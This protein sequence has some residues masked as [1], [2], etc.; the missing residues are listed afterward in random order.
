LAKYIDLVQVLATND[1]GRY[2]FAKS[3]LDRDAIEYSVK[4]EAIRMAHG[5]TDS[6]WTDSVMEP[7][8]FWVRSE[9]AERALL[10]L[11]DLDT[12]PL[13]GDADQNGDA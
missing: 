5:W 7:V 12:Q 1:L 4:G 6:H 8:E 3:L 2:L 10:I 13:G 11:R 9:D